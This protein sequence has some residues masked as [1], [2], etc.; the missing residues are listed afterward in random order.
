MIDLEFVPRA[1]VPELWGAP[2]GAAVLDR[3]VA[4]TGRR[5]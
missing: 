2:A 3:V 5:P 4:I 1:P